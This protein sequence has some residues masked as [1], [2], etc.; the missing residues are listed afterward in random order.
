MRISRG[1]SV[2]FS[3]VRAVSRVFHPISA[4]WRA[5]EPS[6]NTGFQPVPNLL[7]TGWKPVIPKRLTDSHSLATIIPSTLPTRRPRCSTPLALFQLPLGFDLRGVAHFL[8]FL[9]HLIRRKHAG[10]HELGAD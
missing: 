6:R 7:C 1:S 3:R 10:G 8:D 2:A 9:Q 4:L 5:R